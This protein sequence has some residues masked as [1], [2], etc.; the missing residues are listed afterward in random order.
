MLLGK[1][2]GGDPT[3]CGAR[4]GLDS[5]LLSSHACAPQSKSTRLPPALPQDWIAA[6]IADAIK[7][8][9]ATDK[10]KGKA[11]AAAAGAAPP[12]NPLALPAEVA[13]R[14]TKELKIHAHQLGGCW[15]AALYAAP[16]MQGDACALDALVGLVARR[17]RDAQAQAVDQGP[18]G[19]TIVDVGGGE[20]EGP[21]GGG[22]GARRRVALVARPGFARLK[23]PSAGGPVCLGAR[24]A[25]ARRGSPCLRACLS[26]GGGPGWP[27][28]IV[29]PPPGLRE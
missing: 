14:V 15:E 19:K 16:G 26:P 6:A 27:P 23:R 7:A 9:A 25:R 8:A 22:R 20:G 11:P 5:Q 24:R 1:V 29:W 3:A 21:Q 2:R 4:L 10:G 18:G 28:G 12:P 13:A 17:L